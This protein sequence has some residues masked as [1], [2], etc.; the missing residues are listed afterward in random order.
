M[1]GL[2]RP[3]TKER[4]DAYAIQLQNGIRSLNEVRRLEDL[5]DIEGGDQHWKPLN[6]GTVGQEPEA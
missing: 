5:S 1:D 6:I 4:M 2:L 3:T